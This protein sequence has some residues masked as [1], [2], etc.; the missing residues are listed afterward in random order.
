MLETLLAEIRKGGTLQPAGLAARLQVSP[1]LIEMMLEDLERRGL[2]AQV[3][4]ACSEPC[5]GCPMVG[6]CGVT[7][8]N[9]R[10]WMLV[11]KNPFPGSGHSLDLAPLRNEPFAPSAG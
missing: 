8:T 6:D 4:P 3:N 1:A 5:G 10:M 7:G 11:S 9:G 2:V